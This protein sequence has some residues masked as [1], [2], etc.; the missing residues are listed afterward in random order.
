MAREN[1]KIAGTGLA[2]IVIGAAAAAC[3]IDLVPVD[4]LA[5]C[6]TCLVSGIGIYL[7]MRVRERWLI[8]VALFLAVL[9]LVG[10]AAAAYKV[11]TNPGMAPNCPDRSGGAA[12]TRLGRVPACAF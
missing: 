12:G 6:W 7:M 3:G 1:L 5:L 10:P 8:P 2:T 4:V 9:G 11:V